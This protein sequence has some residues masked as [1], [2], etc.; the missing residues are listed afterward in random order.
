MKKIAGIV[1]SVMCLSIFSPIIFAQES[2]ENTIKKEMEGSM[3]S[4]EEMK[5]RREKMMKMPSMHEVMSK[6]MMQSYLVATQDGGIIILSGNK[7]MKYDKNL[8]LIKE[9]K[10]KNDMQEMMNRCKV[11]MKDGCNTEETKAPDV[12]QEATEE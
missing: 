3:M 2:N 1:L 10:I 12:S 4:Q 8:N 7:L 6:M 5:A 9:V 11:M